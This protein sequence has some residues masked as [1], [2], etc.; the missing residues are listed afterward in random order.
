MLATVARTSGGRHMK[1]RTSQW[2]AVALLVAVCAV[3]S[4][5]APNDPAD[6]AMATIRPEALRADMRFLSDDRL[7]GRRTGTR[8]HEIAAEYIASRF[9]G[10]G[11]A[12]AG[13]QGSYFQQVPF[14]AAKADTAKTIMSWT[15]NGKESALAFGKDF[16]GRQI[17]R[18]RMFLSRRRWFSSATES[19]HRSC[20][21]TTI[22]G[23]TRR[24]R[25]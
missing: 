14:R 13:D 19:H 4:P 5:S 16:I 15:A 6:Q 8:G 24:A 20:I 7:E 21:M 9:E 2:L 12:P 3:A 22:R 23:L 18:A 10:M 17:R 25:S 11:L 1:L